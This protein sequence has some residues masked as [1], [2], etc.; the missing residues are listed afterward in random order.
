[1]TADEAITYVRLQSQVAETINYLY[2]L[3]ENQRLLG[4]LWLRELFNSP[5]DPLVHEVMRPD[6]VTVPDRMDQE[7]VA[8]IFARSDLIALPVVDAENR[9]KGIIRIDDMVDV[10]NEEVSEDIRSSAECKHSTP[11]IWT[12]GF[13][14]CCE[15]TPA[16]W[17]LSSSER[18]SRR[19]R[20]VGIRPTLPK[21]SWLRYSFRSSSA[22][23]T[24]G[25]KPP[26][27]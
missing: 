15:S 5:K 26:H 24:Q 10:V 11:R 2:L 16:G 6:V 9:M 14:V 3:D 18:C 8:Q 1:M 23:E 19:Q 20:W 25:R 13:G 17:R 12:L 27:W 7:A 21:L 4:V 22:E